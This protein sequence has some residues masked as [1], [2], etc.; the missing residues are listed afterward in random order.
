MSRAAGLILFLVILFLP[1]CAGVRGPARIQGSIE[2]Q[3]AALLLSGLEAQT[4]RNC[5]VKGIGRIRLWGESNLP[6]SRMAWLGATD[7]RLRMEVMGPSG[8]PFAKLVYDGKGY[9]L[10]SPY[11]H[12]IYHKSGAD[13]SLEPLTGVPIRA[14]EIVF[15][16]AG[17][18][19][20]YAHDRVLLQKE[21][22]ADV[23]V[24][25]KRFGGVVEKIY[26]NSDEKRVQKVEVFCRGRLVYY[27]EL[28]RIKEVN[29][30]GIPFDLVVATDQEAGFSLA[31]D[32][33]WTDF[34][35]TDEMFLLE[36]P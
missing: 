33:C 28:D 9:S 35:V 22:A 34:S 2:S 19:P 15:Y 8:Q 18:I 3:Q 7:G 23:L 36:Q 12:A 14:S 16:L 25:K 13:P 20:V 11:E 31:V 1:A 6:V 17:L 30:Y 29:G 32:R 5:F 21:N 10:L 4:G 26:I 24:L 27:A